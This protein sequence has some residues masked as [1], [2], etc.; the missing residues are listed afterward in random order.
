MNNAVRKTKEWNR[1]DCIELL[2]TIVVKLMN[3]AEKLVNNSAKSESKWEILGYIY[4][5]P[6]NCKQE[7]VA[8]IWVMLGSTV[9]LSV[10]K[11]ARTSYN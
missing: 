6:V 10:D 5:N 11:P 3:K 2:M 7:K 9:P 4:A 1:Q 8:N